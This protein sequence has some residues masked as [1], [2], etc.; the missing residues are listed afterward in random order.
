MGTPLGPSEPPKTLLGG[1]VLAYNLHDSMGESAGVAVIHG[2]D[3]GIWNEPTTLALEPGQASVNMVGPQFWVVSSRAD[4]RVSRDGGRT[5]LATT[6]SMSPPLPEHSVTTMEFASELDAIAV[7]I[8]YSSNE[9]Y[10]KRSTYVSHDG[11]RTFR[12]TG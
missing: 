4:L 1:I 8:D 2:A 11:G 5:W 3:P 7:V 12:L 6:S 10:K 9:N